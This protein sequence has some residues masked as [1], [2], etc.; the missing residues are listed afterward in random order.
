MK[1]IKVSKSAGC[2]GPIVSKTVGCRQA[3]PLEMILLNFN[4]DNVKIWHF[5][6]SQQEFRIAEDAAAIMV[7]SV[8][9]ASLK[10]QQETRVGIYIKRHFF[11]LPSVICSQFGKLRDDLSIVEDDLSPSAET[12]N[13]VRFQPGM[14]IPDNC[15]YR[16]LI[17]FIIFHMNRSKSCSQRGHLNPVHTLCSI[18]HSD[19]YGF[20]NHWEHHGCPFSQILW[21]FWPQH[22]HSWDEQHFS[23]LPLPLCSALWKW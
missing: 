16:G 23:G 4:H 5:I 15:N 3:H 7:K 17:H 22:L 19:Q 13:V 2:L 21:L 14:V 20:C 6:L 10:L 12:E 1:K 8:S 18:S 11:M 9:G